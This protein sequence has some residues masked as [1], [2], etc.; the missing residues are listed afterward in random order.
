MPR[1]DFANMPALV[2]SG[3]PELNKLLATMR[4]NIELLCGLRGDAANH[5]VVKG[6]I[7]QDYPDEP[8]SNSLAELTKLKEVVRKL[9]V[10]LKT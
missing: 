9:M 6:D 5:A 1:R 10:N 2:D 7:E 8:A 3:N 4:E